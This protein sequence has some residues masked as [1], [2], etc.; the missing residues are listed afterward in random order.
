[1]SAVSSRSAL[2]SCCIAFAAAHLYKVQLCSFQQEWPTLTEK[3]M[4]GL[5]LQ[6]AVIVNIPSDVIKKDGYAFIYDVL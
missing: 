3:E 2:G 5:L 4:N 6:I 1:M